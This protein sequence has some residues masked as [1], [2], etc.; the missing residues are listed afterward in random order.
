MY[1]HTD[2]DGHTVSNVNVFPTTGLVTIRTRMLTGYTSWTRPN[3]RTI[4]RVIDAAIRESEAPT[5]RRID[6][7]NWSTVEDGW[8]G[9]VN[10]ATVQNSGQAA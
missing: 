7:V 4:R 1:T 10:I 2:H 5:M 6:R 8:W 9:V 3:A